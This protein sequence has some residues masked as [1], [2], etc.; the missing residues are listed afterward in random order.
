MGL[1]VYVSRAHDSIHFSRQLFSSPSPKGTRRPNPSIIARRCLVLLHRR[2]RA[3]FAPLRRVNPRGSRR[4]R[5]L[6]IQRKDQTA[7]AFSFST[8][9]TE[10][11]T[12]PPSHWSSH[13]RETGNRAVLIPLHKP[14]SPLPPSP[15]FSPP[16]SSCRRHLLHRRETS[17]CSPNSI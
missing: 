10:T 1:C 12:E 2:D 15:S 6:R 3:G 7:V 14:V 5:L 9:E 4:R 17:S 16:H 8:A 13:R 11:E